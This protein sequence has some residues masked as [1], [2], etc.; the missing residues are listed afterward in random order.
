MRFGLCGPPEGL[1]SAARCGF[2]YYETHVTGL[3]AMD[4]PAFTEFV[5]QA[6]AAPIR[7]ESCCILF[8]GSGEVPIVGDTFD[9]GVL[10]G[11][12]RR[13]FE[14]IRRVGA[15]RTAFGSGGLRRTPAGW[16]KSRAWAQLAETL[17]LTAALAGSYGVTVL[18]EPL[19]RGETDTVISIAE[20]VAMI[21]EVGSPNLKL[22]ADWYHMS[23]ENEPASALAAAA[24]VLAH[25]HIASREMRGYPLPDD[26][27]EY[28]SFFRAL[29]ENGYDGRMSIEGGSSQPD[30]DGPAALAFFEK[31]GIFE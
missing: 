23:R 14:R 22:L 19:N 31:L 20:G 7:V 5:K 21:A 29:S 13:A 28:T 10:E 30:R 2:D 9:R 25:A 27:G 17:S 3:M 12:L 24:G 6:E 16:E 18:L 15:D 4:E 8:P 1:A 26:G 11:Y